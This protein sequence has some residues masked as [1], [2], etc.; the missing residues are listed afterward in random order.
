MG[1]RV[2]RVV[3]LLV[4]VYLV[5]GYMRMMSFRRRYMALGIDGPPPTLL[6]GNIPDIFRTGGL[7][8]AVKRFHLISSTP[9]TPLKPLIS[10]TIL[11][12]VGWH[13]K[14]G[15][16]FLTWRFGTPVFEV[17]DAEFM[18]IILSSKVYDV[19]SSHLNDVIP[20]LFFNFFLLDFPIFIPPEILSVLFLVCAV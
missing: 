11:R 18:K 13:K 5:Q 6:L 17:S 1:S 2:S 14:Y 12:Q 4:A 3:C 15:R 16:L 20:S 9:E 10:F 8:G 19:I 7:R